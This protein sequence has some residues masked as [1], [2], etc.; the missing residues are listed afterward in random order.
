M[1]DQSFPGDR[2]IESDHRQEQPRPERVTRRDLAEGNAEKV[3]SERTEAVQLFKGGGVD[4]A[5]LRDMVDAAK[6]LSTAGPMLKP[7]LQ[8]NVGGCFAICLRA[9][10]LGVSPLALAAW[11]YV[12]EQY[13]GGHKVEQVAYESQ[14]FHGVIELHVTVAITTKSAAAELIARSAR[15]PARST[16]RSAR[17]SRRSWQDYRHR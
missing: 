9:Q 8:G 17:A 13:Q 11:T 5:N 16:A 1:S 4:Y 10:E 12:V 15:F 14:M 7:W 6:L 2:P 3:V